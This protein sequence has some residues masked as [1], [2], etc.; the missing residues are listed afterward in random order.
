MTGGNPLPS[1]CPSCGGGM[2]APVARCEACGVEASGRFVP[3]PVCALEGEDR[4]LFSLF[5]AARGNLKKVERALGISYPTVR[6][7]VDD[8][9]TRLGWPKDPTADR[10]EVLRRLRDGEIGLEEAERLLR[11]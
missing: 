9:L 7:R 3:C 1:R 11:R 8:L 6:Q 4:R 5:L 2:T 10:L